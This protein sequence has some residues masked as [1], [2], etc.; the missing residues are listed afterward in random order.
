MLGYFLH[1]PESIFPLHGIFHSL[2]LG[3]L[4]T[5]CFLWGLEAGTRSSAGFVEQLSGPD[6][7]LSVF[8]LS[9][10]LSCISVSLHSPHHLY[11]QT[12]VRCFCLYRL[13]VRIWTGL[14]RFHLLQE[15]CNFFRE[16]LFCAK[17]TK[18]RTYFLD[19][20]LHPL[21]SSLV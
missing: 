14:L 9:C 2:I 1:E 3:C 19:I 7:G 12:S 15:C 13:L 5:G 11:H 17:V 18:N 4:L 21:H 6:F 10:F 16:L 8:Y 20:S